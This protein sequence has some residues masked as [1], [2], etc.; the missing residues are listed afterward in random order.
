MAECH[1]SISKLLDF[2]NE[3]RKYNHEF[4][5]IIILFRFYYTNEGL[6]EVST[7]L[8]Q[9]IPLDSLKD[10]SIKF[11][12][13]VCKLASEGN[14]WMI[15]KLRSDERVNRDLLTLIDL[16][17][18]SCK[19]VFI[20]NIIRAYPIVSVSWMRTLLHTDESPD[21]LKGLLE[22]FSHDKNVD[23]SESGDKFV[24]KKKK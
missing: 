21:S 17:C 10:P 15:K 3:K 1:I 9:K 6:A 22:S 20:S 13:R 18:E 8:R 16:I 24:L 19:N 11:A 12:L 4:L 7:I 23:L 5:A 14:Y 2:Y